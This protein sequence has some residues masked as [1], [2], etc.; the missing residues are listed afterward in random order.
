MMQLK[1]KLTNVDKDENILRSLFY[2]AVII[3]SNVWI[4]WIWKEAAMD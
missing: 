4:E 2:V 1:T 3:A